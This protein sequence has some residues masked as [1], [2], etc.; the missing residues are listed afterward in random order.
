MISNKEDFHTEIKQIPIKM[1]NFVIHIYIYFLNKSM[2]N[3]QYLIILY[4]N[5]FILIMVEL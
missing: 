4:N 3:I 1:M 2:M 5:T